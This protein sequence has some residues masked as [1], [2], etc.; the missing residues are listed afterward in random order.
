MAWRRGGQR[1]TRSAAR[2]IDNL[3]PPSTIAAQIVYNRSNVARQEPEN[4][5][6]FGKLLQEYL[7]DPVVEEANVETNAQQNN[8]VL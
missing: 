1:S 6:L 7:R 3:P 5:A 8:F 2:N 4:E